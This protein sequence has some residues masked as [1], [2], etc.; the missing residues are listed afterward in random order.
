MPPRGLQNAPG[1][2][3]ADP[4]HPGDPWITRGVQSE[5]VAVD[6]PPLVR[7]VRRVTVAGTVPGTP[8]IVATDA[9]GLVLDKGPISVRLLWY[10][11]RKLMRLRW[12]T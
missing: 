1:E 4:V 5:A 3:G 11:L 12:G 6:L 2:G 10:H 8:V 7:P 9:L